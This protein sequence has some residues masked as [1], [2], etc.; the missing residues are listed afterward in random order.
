MRCSDFP[1]PRRPKPNAAATIRPPRDRVKGT[2]V[3]RVAVS[4]RHGTER[5]CVKVADEPTFR[6][7]SPTHPLA[8]RAPA[9]LPGREK[10]VA[11]ID[12]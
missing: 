1:P 3:W 8:Q 7:R 5:V 4:L 2:A 11:H 9:S 12:G 10:S 6:L